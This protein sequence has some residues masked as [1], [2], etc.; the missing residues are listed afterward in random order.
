[1]LLTQ[2]LDFMAE[3]LIN[4]IDVI[5]NLFFIINL[6]KGSEIFNEKLKHFFDVFLNFSLI[7]NS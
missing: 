3:F 4:F 2:R 5:E 1:M 7:F 6:E